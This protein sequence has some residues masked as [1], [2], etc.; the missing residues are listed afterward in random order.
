MKTSQPFQTAFDDRDRQRAHDRLGT[1]D[2]VGA[3]R[4]RDPMWPGEDERRRRPRRPA[5]SV[6][7]RT[8]PALTLIA[9]A[10]VRASD[11]S[12][13]DDDGGHTL[14]AASGIRGSTTP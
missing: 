2:G 9:E 8:P 1:V 14:V 7:S 6:S 5:G 13:W 12:R 3:V 11:A 4:L 10:T